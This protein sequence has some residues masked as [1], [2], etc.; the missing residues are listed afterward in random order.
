MEKVRSTIQIEIYEEGGFNVIEGDKCSEHLGYDEMLGLVSALTMPES[1]PCLQWMRTKE[2]H[3]RQR[4]FIE[5][6]PSEV[7]FEDILVPEDISIFKL[8]DGY[9]YGDGLF[10]EI[11]DNQLIGYCRASF[12]VEPKHKCQL[13]KV[14]CKLIPCKREDLKGGDTAFANLINDSTN[15]LSYC[16][17]LNDK[18]V[19]CTNSRSGVDI[20]P[21]NEPSLEWH[22]V[23][24]L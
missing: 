2:E 1:R 18:E 8:P 20:K 23:V 3:Q 11:S 14:Q 12:I 10:I 19:A 15:K 22:K 24:A 17:I 16:K 5:N 6:L 13:N 9:E 7:E 4:G 21:W